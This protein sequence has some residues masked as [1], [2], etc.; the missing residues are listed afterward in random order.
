MNHLGLYT[1]HTHSP[2]P[3][4]MPPRTNSEHS[5]FPRATK[6]SRKR[7]THAGICRGWRRCRSSG[8]R[9]VPAPPSGTHTRLVIVPRDW[10][11]QLFS[12]HENQ[13]HNTGIHDVV[14]FIY[15]LGFVFKEQIQFFL[16]IVSIYIVGEMLP[17]LRTRNKLVLILYFFL[18]S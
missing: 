7:L 14:K 3:K 2:T 4:Q 10:W 18:R 1:K 16:W 11:H 13:Y 12:Y 8:L 17:S 6:Q 15:M 5:P 9:A